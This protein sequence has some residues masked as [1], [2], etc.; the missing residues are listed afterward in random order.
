MARTRRTTWL[1]IAAAVLLAVLIALATL[2]RPAP[3]GV[4]ATVGEEVTVFDYSTDACGRLDL[5]DTPARAFRD[6]GGTVNLLASHHVTRRA[7]G[8]N[9]DSLTRDCTVVMESH[10]DPRPERFDDREWIASLY[11]PDGRRVA[12]LVHNEYQGHRHAGRCPSESYRRCWYNSITLAVS[13]DGGRSF[14]HAEPP[15]HLVA[16]LPERYVPDIGPQGVFSASNI[17][18]GRGD[19]WFYAMFHLQSDDHGTG[20]CVMRT[21]DP[22]DA[23]SWRAWDGEGF[24]VDFADPYREEPE[25]EFCRPVSRD[26]I[27]TMRHSLTYNTYLDRYLLVGPNQGWDA[28]REEQVSGIY[29][30]TSKDLVSWSPRTLIMEAE[31]PWTF[32]CGDDAPV[33]YP[34]LLDPES[35]ARNFDVTGRTG[36]LYFTRLNYRDCR[37]TL[38]RDLIRVPVTLRKAA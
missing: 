5:P 35:P 20:T 22:F 26:R 31:L 37:Q 16:A 32:E 6:A 3:T 28:A 11:T 27:G 15:D 10:A 18:P 24:S 17:V 19:G 23:G 7:T 8:P 25:G 34:S 1:P 38:D 12:A 36:Y 9:L 4:E 29:L 21:R 2:R 33:N 13:E 30:S 14:A